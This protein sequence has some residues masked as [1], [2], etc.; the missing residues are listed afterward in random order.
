MIKSFFG[1]KEYAL[2]AWGGF[3]LLLSITWLQVYLTVQINTWYGEFYNILQKAD[4][5]NAFWAS[6]LKFAY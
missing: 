2:W 1:T 5:I 3:L 6:M 4:D